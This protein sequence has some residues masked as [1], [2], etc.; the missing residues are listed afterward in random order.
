MDR[1]TSLQWMAR[2]AAL[3]LLAPALHDAGAAV[4][5]PAAK[6]YGTDPKIVRI[7]RSGQLWPLTMT[8][9]QRET[10]R[11]LCDLVIPAD[12]MSPSAGALDVHVFVDEWISAPYPTQQRDRTLLL[13]GLAWLDDEATR[14]F[15]QRF[16]ATE[17]PQQHE[18]L[19]AIHWLPQAAADLVEPARFFAR[20]RDLAAG[21]FYTTPQG[22]QDLRYVGNQ[23]SASFDG[24]PPEVLALVGVT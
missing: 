18:I 7:H 3:P 14:R 12:S 23:P 11:V 21:G 1:R 19:Q 9:A 17:E 5:A 2:A 22:S 13:Q 15:G 6:G 8:A 10:T 4:V 24:P 16:V 20:F